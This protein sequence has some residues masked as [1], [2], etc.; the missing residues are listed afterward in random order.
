M[1]AKRLSHLRPLEEEGEQFIIVPGSR[2][3][4][5]EFEMEEADTTKTMEPARGAMRSQVQLQKE[6]G[7]NGRESEEGVK[8]KV[9]TGKR[10][11]GEGAREKK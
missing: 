9:I 6:Q 1:L 4:D 2:E 10:T 7:D 8:S 11:R 3:G 5:R